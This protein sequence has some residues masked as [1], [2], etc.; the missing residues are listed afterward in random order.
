MLMFRYITEANK[1]T[2]MALFPK[3]L[4]KKKIPSN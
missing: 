1:T 2:T 3:E 4:K